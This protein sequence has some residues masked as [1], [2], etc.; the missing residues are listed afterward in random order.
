MKLSSD[1]FDIYDGIFWLDK[2]AR[3]KLDDARDKGKKYGEG[4]TIIKKY[5][6]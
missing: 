6:R 1:S 5:K 2:D 3:E 4:T